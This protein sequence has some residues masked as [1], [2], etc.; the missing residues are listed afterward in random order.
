MRVLTTVG[1]QALQFNTGKKQFVA[2][3]NVPSEA[4]GLPEVP[5]GK[6]TFDAAT[7]LFMRR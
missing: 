4:I 5:A 7:L 3:R 2:A 1:F 6:L